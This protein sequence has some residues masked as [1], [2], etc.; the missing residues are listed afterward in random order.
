MK[1]TQFRIGINAPPSEVYNK[2][3]GIHNKDTYS[4][5]AK[6]FNPTSRYE[7]DWEEGSKIAF[8][9]TSE[10]GKQ[11]GI[12]CIITK[13]IPNQYLSMRTQGLIEDGVEIAEGPGLDQWQN[14]EESYWFDETN[15]ATNLTIEVEIPD[16]H[17]EI[18]SSLWPKALEK[19]KSIIE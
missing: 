8:I 1:K 6:I 2:M 19:L 16:D 7:G 18:F 11:E 15:G 13:N 14:L 10:E 5:W 17:V 12:F 4:Q 3:L 9:G